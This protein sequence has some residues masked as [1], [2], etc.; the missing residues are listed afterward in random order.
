MTLAIMTIAA[1]CS[2][3][4]LPMMAKEGS[5]MFFFIGF[6]A[7]LFLLPAALVAAELGGAFSDQKG[8]VYTW[9][10]A[11][12]GS[13][14]GFTAIWLQWIQNVVWYPSVLAFA[15]AALA[16]LI[17]RPELASSGAYTGI[18]IIVAYWAATFIALS[19]AG[20]ASKVTS[21]GTLL[22]T[23][24]PG[25]LIIGL[26]VAWW[27]GGNPNH[28]NDVAQAGSHA[29]ARFMPHLTDLSSLAFLGGIILLFA[30]VEVHAV[31]ANELDKPSTQFP[32]AIFIAI[33]V[34]LVLFGA[35]S[36]ALAAM[37][38]NAE[39]DLNQG[40]M[41]AYNV[42]LTHFDM[43]WLLAPLGLFIAFGAFAGV[44]SWITGPSRG[45]L[46]TAQEGEIPPFLAKTNKNGVQIH[47]LMVQG[48][49]V[50]V[51]ALLYFVLDNVSVA[52]F[53]LSAMTITLYLVMY[54]LMYA[55]GIKL[56]YTQPDLKRAYKVPGGNLGMWLIAGIGLL[57][58]IFAFVVSFVPP[59][60]LPI[61]NPT[62]YV[63]L[64]AGGFIIFCGLP[65]VIHA[66]KKPSW[67]VASDQGS[68]S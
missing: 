14:W 33:A 12:F 53:L 35:G 60:Q 6:S 56:R 7:I 47:I 52:F 58:V 48:A 11:A 30:G 59:N 17:G 54:M 36:M 66:C 28:M 19:G 34:I 22:G 42:A 57:G 4:G 20:L 23:I 18:V 63:A 32:Q 55:A 49:I 43:H 50:T 3:R 62:L 44:M 46:Q 45:L 25:V 40:L 16:Y 64:V 31:H 67:K 51:L 15:A 39:I 68:P 8:G 41:Q 9:V 2:L 24:L 27:L 1:V 37:V 5:E 65:L 61:G 10:S 21:L 13:R 26:G 29:H 38:P